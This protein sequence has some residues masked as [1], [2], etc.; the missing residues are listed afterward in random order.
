MYLC[1]RPMWFEIIFFLCVFQ[2][3]VIWGYSLCVFVSVL[4]FRVE[5]ALSEAVSVLDVGGSRECYRP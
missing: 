4:E 3:E 5:V 2:I 1:F